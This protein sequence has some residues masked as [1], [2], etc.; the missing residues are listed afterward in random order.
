MIYLSKKYQTPNWILEVLTVLKPP[1]KLT[2]SEWAEK[3]RI[4]DNKT[5]AIPGQWRTSKTPYLEGIMNSF[6]DPEI[7]EIIFVKPTQVGGTECLNN[8]VG[9]IVAQDPSPTLVV[10]PTLDLAEYTSDNRLQPMFKIS[11]ALK[12]K[13]D[14]KSKKL[15]LQ[16]DGMYI[17]LSGANCPASLASRPI[18]FLLL[19]EVD[20]YPIN[21]GKE[22][23]PT[24][25]ARER[26]KTFANNKKIF[27]TST[28]TLKTGPIWQEWE[29]ADCQLSILYLVLIVGPIKFLIFTS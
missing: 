9:Y 29:N 5:S 26:T 18:R 24:S 1:E 28:P 14:E 7:E 25:L 8:I 4:L 11:P 19:D 3:Y 27:Q 22:A 12:D 20:K 23:D 17:V 16:C 15:E 13:F 6:N 10:Y 21:S 2:V